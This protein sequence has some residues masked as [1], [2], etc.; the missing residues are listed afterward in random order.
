MDGLVY[1]SLSIQFL[2]ST[3]VAFR[4]VMSV[5]KPLMEVLM[6]VQMVG[7]LKMGLAGWS[8]LSGRTQ[9]STELP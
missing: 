9:K 8:S 6:L 1:V 7:P 5:R 3:I 2:N 4:V